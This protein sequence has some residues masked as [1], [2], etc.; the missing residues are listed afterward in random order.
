MCHVNVKYDDGSSC[1]FQ[2]I[3][4]NSAAH[5]FPL[6]FICRDDEG[7]RKVLKGESGP[8]PV[9]LMFEAD[10][11]CHFADEARINFCRAGKL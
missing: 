1:R 5:P 4:G 10:V 6:D 2:F 11:P 3:P 7:V 9:A 8:R